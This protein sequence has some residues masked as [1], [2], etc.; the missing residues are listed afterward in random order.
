MSALLSLVLA[1]TLTASS[2][3]SVATPP[4]VAMSASH[5]SSSGSASSFPHPTYYV[6]SHLHDSCET[7]KKSEKLYLDEFDFGQTPNQSIENSTSL[8]DWKE[9]FFLGN[10]SGFTSIVESANLYYPYCKQDSDY[11][12]FSLYAQS[13]VSISCLA[14][15]ATDKNGNPVKDSYFDFSLYGLVYGQA[16]EEG[17]SKSIKTIFSDSGKSS[18]SFSGILSP[19]TYYVQAYQH[20]SQ[21]DSNVINYTL[22]VNADYLHASK[23]YDIASLRYNKGIKAAIWSADYRPFQQGA[24]ANLTCTDSFSKIDTFQ[25]EHCFW[26]Y[27]SND[28]MP[29]FAAKDLEELLSGVSLYTDVL[30]VWDNDLAAL[31]CDTFS[32]LASEFQRKGEELKENAQE[33]KGVLKTTKI[34]YETVTDGLKLILD[35]LGVDISLLIPLPKALTSVSL[36]V[37]EKV[38][39][40]VFSSLENE[41]D[42]EGKI[43]DGRKDIADYF[44]LI[45]SYLSVKKD[46]DHS[47]GAPEKVIRIPLG[48][49]RMESNT[50]LLGAR[51]SDCVIS[52]AQTLVDLFNQNYQE[53]L[54]LVYDGDF[55]STIEVENSLPL[56]GNVYAFDAGNGTT[57]EADSC[58]DVMHP[59]QTIYD[60]YSDSGSVNRGD[61]SWYRFANTSESQAYGML[62]TSNEPVCLEPYSEQILGFS[63]ENRNEIALTG[64]YVKGTKC[65]AFYDF[66]LP[67]GE[68]IYFRVSPRSLSHLH[69][70]V[71]FGNLDSLS[72]F[73]RDEGYCFLK[74]LHVHELTFYSCDPFAIGY[75]PML[76]HCHSCW[77]GDLSVIEKHEFGSSY[78]GSDGK[79]YSSCLKCHYQAQ[80]FLLNPIGPITCTL[81]LP[82]SS[83]GIS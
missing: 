14:T 35:L 56:I 32:S 82:G 43:S 58:K 64:T 68:D 31:L 52:G 76:S 59:Y 12:T 46:T 51:K 77:K 38:I 11:Y 54:S 42:A 60:G 71:N 24:F 39:D 44:R 21:D 22:T 5:S 26:D 55:I 34:P 48:A 73:I 23:S 15:S 81:P 7:E 2:G 16:E 25:T 4:S 50:G 28:R 74:D 13:M 65:Y 9:H 67:Q 40:Y 70:T 53:S 29:D 1:S 41:Y 17:Y 79:T 80:T 45:S 75:K 3:V 66:Y 33:K 49:F 83:G 20:Y 61:Y 57:V 36:S 69:F 37:A 72:N 6:K 47:Q 19:G 78:T 10:Y 18:F 27:S 30:Y 63:P 8:M 62:V